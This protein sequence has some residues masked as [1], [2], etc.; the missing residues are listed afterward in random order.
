MYDNFW[1]LCPDEWT[2]V[3]SNRDYRLR[4]VSDVADTIV[5]GIIYIGAQPGFPLGR[6]AIA[7]RLVRAPHRVGEVAV[8]ILKHLFGLVQSQSVSITIEQIWIIYH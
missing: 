1:E 7:R 4:R 2:S 8:Q 6:G 3:A 5:T